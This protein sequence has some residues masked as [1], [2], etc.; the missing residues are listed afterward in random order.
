MIFGHCQNHP[1]QTFKRP[2]QPK[3]IMILKL[4]L[5][6]NKHYIEV[7]L[8][9]NFYLSAKSSSIFL[10]SFLHVYGEPFYET[11][12]TKREKPNEK[13]GIKRKKRMKRKQSRRSE[14]RKRSK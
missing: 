9:S 3:K 8:V 13:L 1:N 7:V 6:K 14:Q 4:F 2:Y 12:Y 5:S 11:P 10:A